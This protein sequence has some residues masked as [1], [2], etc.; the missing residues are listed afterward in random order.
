MNNHVLKIVADCLEDLHVEYAFG[1]YGKYPVVYPYFVGELQEAEPTTEDG[2]QTAT[3][4]ITG[5][6]RGTWLELQQAK[7]LIEQFFTY[8]GTVF[9]E[10]DGS[11]AVISYSNAFII[12]QDDMELKSIQINL[13]IQEWKV[14]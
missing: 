14:S 13:S 4:I 10:P 1:S 3:M 11:S 8:E 2:L 5:F 7:Q 6:T 9:K 12:P